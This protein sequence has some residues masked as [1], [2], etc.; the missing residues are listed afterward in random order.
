M[1]EFIETPLT[2]EQIREREQWAIEAAEREAAEEAKLAARVSA[3]E[4]LTS[5]GLTED[6]IK[7]VI[8]L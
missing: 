5:L 6:E 8:G 1:T 7:A 2:P 4:K 3:L